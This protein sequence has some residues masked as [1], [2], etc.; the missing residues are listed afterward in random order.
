MA[1]RPVNKVVNVMP[2]AP[3]HYRSSLP[4]PEPVPAQ[5]SDKLGRNAEGHGHNPARLHDGFLPD[6][7]VDKGAGHHMT[8]FPVHGADHDA[9]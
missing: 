2:A 4:M 3:A 8:R 9:V 1:A 5:H 7:G 6:V